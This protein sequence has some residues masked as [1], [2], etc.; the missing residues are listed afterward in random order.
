MKK[1][2]LSVLCL[3]IVNGINAQTAFKHLDINRVD[4][5]IANAGD[6]HWNVLGNGSASYEVP[7]GSGRHSGFAASLWIGGLDASNVLRTAAQTYRQA[8][9]DFWPGPLDTTNATISAAAMASYD[10][11]WKVS[12]LDINNFITNF[13][14][15]NVA[16]NTF[17]PTIDILTWPAKGTGNF[18]K[19]LA[20]F[21]DNNNNGIYDPLTGGDYPKIKGDEA[22]Y[23]IFND[24]Y[25][26]HTETGGLPLG[27]EV[28][29][30]AYAYGCPS[31][32][33]GKNELAYTTFYDYKI[34]NRSVNNYHNVY[35]GFWNDADLGCYTDDYIGCSVNDNLGFMYNSSGTDLINCSGTPSYGNYPPAIGSTMLKG[36]LAP[37]G[38]GLDNN[39]NGNVD[40][41]GEEC[42]MNKF[43][44]YNNNIGNFPA[45]TTNP[46]IATD[47][48]GYLKGQWKDGSDFTC[49]GNAYGG[50]TKTDFV[51]PQTNYSGNPCGNWTEIS[52]GNMAGDRRYLLSSGPFNFAVG[53]VTEVEYAYVW[54]VDSTSANNNMG[55]LNKLITDVQKVRNFYNVQ[56]KPSCLLTITTDINE[57]ELGVNSTLYPNPTNSTIFINYGGNLNAKAVIQIVDVLG[58][59]VLSLENDNLDHLPIDMSKF[60]N[61][62]YFVSIKVNGATTVK[63]VVKQ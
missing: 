20:P 10:K 48:Y 30:M 6:M 37:P 56:L 47:Y 12:Y 16:N 63:K 60:D 2:I 7:K 25:A 11:I 29:A 62:L 9:S 3:S 15:G 18:S 1:L 13:N 42:L 14:N 22:L 58:K 35:L 44:Y 19:N 31:S 53:Q 17:T 51:Y 49:G 38:D 61:G 4:A 40:E 43:I 45:A 46:A 41:P 39:N 32:I 5:G 59:T 55:S 36:P 54:A 24:T 33:A 57:N 50:S 8:G 23:F 27:I 34:I 28:Q 26:A 21:V 52:A